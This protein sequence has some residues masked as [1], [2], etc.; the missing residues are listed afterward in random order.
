MQTFRDEGHTFRDEGM[1][2]Q[3]IR[4]DASRLSVASSLTAFWS[5]A[6]DRCSSTAPYFEGAGTCSSVRRV[7]R[8]TFYRQ[9]AWSG[10]IPRYGE[11]FRTW[12][13]KANLLK[14]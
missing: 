5:T 10:Q 6:G 11:M 4:I 3:T 7:V 2:N 12:C 14:V 8:S 9:S 1:E 13:I